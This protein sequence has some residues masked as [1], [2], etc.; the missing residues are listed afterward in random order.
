MKSDLVEVCVLG[1]TVGLKGALRLHDR[2]DFPNQFK[3][4]AKFYDKFG[5]TF[6]IKSYDKNSNL[7]IF[8][9]FEDLN[10]AKPLVNLVLYRTLEDTKKFC[11]LQKDEFFYFDIIGCAVYED[12]L[13]LGVVDD[14][15]ES[16]AGFL[17]CINTSDELKN[18]GYSDVFYV[19]YLDNF[20]L[21]VDVKTK[22]IQVK[23]SLD[24]LKNS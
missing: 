6:T 12:D 21:S 15:L 20:T 11:K 7:V 18:S 24:I 14:I 5:N 9:G 2:S 19:P 23:N 13:M 8:A 17:F 3:K 1:K 22:K 10:L 4:D 16:G